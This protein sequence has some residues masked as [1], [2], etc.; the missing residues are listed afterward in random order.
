M[1]AQ[2]HQGT[3]AHTSS[4]TQSFT[5]DRAALLCST[6]SYN[7]PVW[8]ALSSNAHETGPQGRKKCN[9][10][11]S[12]SRFPDLN[13]PRP[14]NTLWPDIF[15][16]QDDVNESCVSKWCR[17]SVSSHELVWASSS[18]QLDLRNPEQNKIIPLYVGSTG[19]VPC[20]IRDTPVCK[21]R[22]RFQKVLKAQEMEIV[23][24]P[25]I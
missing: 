2:S 4:V 11:S 22:K 13:A 1:T 7:K 15:S 23:I 24:K 3:Q 14:I 9:L 8:S 25:M 5:L 6:F 12:S 17:E 18:T 19:E 10:V 16:H 20:W 21:L